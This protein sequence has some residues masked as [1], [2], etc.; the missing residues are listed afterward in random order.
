MHGPIETMTTKHVKI[1]QLILKYMDHE[2]TTNTVVENVDGMVKT[3]T[4]SIVWKTADDA[5][6][7]ALAR[8]ADLQDNLQ[9]T[10]AQE[11]SIIAAIAEVDTNLSNLGYTE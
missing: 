11:T 10:Q 6:A 8:K 2:N 5:I 3:T 9:N 7:E 1:Y 4:T